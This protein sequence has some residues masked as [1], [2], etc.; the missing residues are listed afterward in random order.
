MNILNKIFR[1]KK[2]EKTILKLFVQHVENSVAS[3]KLVNQ[4]LI[5][6]FENKKISEKCARIE[7][8]EDENDKI[9][10]TLNKKLFKGNL[11]PYTHE[12]WSKLASM[13][14]TLSDISERLSKLLLIK[15]VRL[16]TKLKND[17]LKLSA[18]S[19]KITELVHET[20]IYMRKDFELAT[21]LN[22][23]IIRLRHE[24]R[25]LEYE[26][27]SN[28]F[29]TK[30]RQKDLLLLK[31]IVYWLAQLANTS[32]EIGKHVSRISVKYNY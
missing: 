15:Q 24:A 29:K 4:V 13:I 20:I 23:N 25:D 2:N 16:N 7:M 21:S 8:L 26:I 10:A 22:D 31:D 11:L 32:K 18:Y 28:I 27:Y 19:V 3:V 1:I 5:D 12:D 6:Y 17:I 9:N 14:D 30:L